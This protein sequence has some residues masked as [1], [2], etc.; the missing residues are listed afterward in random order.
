MIVWGLDISPRRV[1]ITGGDGSV[2]PAIGTWHYEQFG[3]DLGGLLHAFRKDMDT[4]AVRCWPGVVIYESPLLLP[5][6]RIQNL[7]Q[8][9]AMGAFLEYWCQLIGV[10]CEEA[11]VQ[12]LKKRLTGKHNASKMDMVEAAL[13]L[14]MP[15]PAGEGAKDAADSLAAWLVG[16]EHHGS[17]TALTKWDKALYSRR[18]ALAL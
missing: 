10:K 7:R 6:D 15:L 18:G 2:R 8:V 16:L 12:A 9:Y 5:S 1:G 14:R 3:T 13:A 4:F 17:R 11:S